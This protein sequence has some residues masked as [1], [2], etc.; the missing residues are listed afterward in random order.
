MYHTPK[1]TSG[2]LSY[3]FL[4]AVECPSLN[5]TDH[6]EKIG[7]GCSGPTS[8]FGTVCFFSCILGFEVAGG[9]RHR[10]CQENREWSG[11]QLQY[12]GN[13]KIIKMKRLFGIYLIGKNRS[14]DGINVVFFSVFVL[15]DKCLLGFCAS[16]GFCTVFTKYLFTGQ[17]TVDA[18]FRLISI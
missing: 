17:Q 5:T 9:S 7:Y 11:A 14:L 16:F 8:T 6:V 18:V 4:L 10:T 2:T 3:F 1:Y 12:R 15:I 13:K